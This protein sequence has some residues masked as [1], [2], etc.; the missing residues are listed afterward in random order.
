MIAND[1]MVQNLTA[2]STKLYYL[3]SKKACLNAVALEKS[4]VGLERK[5]KG[6][7]WEEVSLM[8]KIISR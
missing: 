1:V 7:A 8:T 3:I 2:S 4:L 6:T 5:R